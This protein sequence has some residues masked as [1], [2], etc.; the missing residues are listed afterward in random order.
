MFSV[1]FVVLLAVLAMNQLSP[2]DAPRPPSA[3]AGV[4]TGRVI[5]AGVAPAV[6]VRRARVTLTGGGLRTPE[7]A[8]TDIQ[9][10]YRFNDLAPGSYRIAASK[11]GFVTMDAGASK[12][13]QRGKAIDLEEGQSF[14][15]DVALPRGAS[16][17]GR[18][19]DESGQPVQDVIV[20]A[21]QLS[22][23][24]IG[25]RP[26]TVRESRTDDLGRYRIHS[27]ADGEYFVQ[28]SPDPRNAVSLDVAGGERPPGLAR[29]YYP[30]TAQ[31]H[32]ARRLRLGVGQE[33]A[34]ID[35]TIARVPVNSVTGRV[36]DSTGKPVTAFGFRMVPVGGFISAGGSALPGDSRFQFSSVPPGDYWLLAS[37]NQGAGR[38]PEFAA[39]R[40]S[41][42][43]ADVSDVT[44]TTA[45]GAVLQ[46]R[47]ETDDGSGLPALTGVRFIAVETEFELPAPRPALPAVSLGADGSFLVNG[48]FG[49][50]IL[51][52]SGLPEGW[53][54]KSVLLDDHDLTDRSH[55][56]RGS[57]APRTLR[58]VLTK[59]TA[60]VTGTV[61]TKQGEE[62]AAYRV[63]LFPTDE[64]QWTASSRFVKDASPGADGRFRIHGV[65]PGD[66]LA[67]ALD[68]L[69]DDLVHDPDVLRG[70][71]SRATAVTLYDPVHRSLDLE[72]QVTK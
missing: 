35:F 21:V 51:R 37:M 56:F 36:I 58:M 34:S 28:A 48:L 12:H 1:P 32:E 39:Q 18:L 2:R 55:D 68:R 7:V 23:S 57:S 16:I 64:R 59:A 29:T 40:L 17:E 63:L 8:D 61:R 38:V 30:G 20:A 45:P 24:A 70:L 6:P 54:L 27:L 69:E 65:L 25:R 3:A 26:R 31:V 53:A 15:A 13:G 47:L 67:V 11:P 10:R 71:R 19:V 43:G 62:V 14:A 41:L 9:G 44:V 52:F 5:V 4:I 49:P 72:L 46:G 22:Y 66:Y 60:T 33:A 42:G 50:R